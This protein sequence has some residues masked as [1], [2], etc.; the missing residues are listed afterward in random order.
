M[1]SDAAYETIK[2]I[3]LRTDPADSY[4]FSENYFSET[5]HM[6]RTPVRAALQ[7][8]QFEELITIIPHQGIIVRDVSYEEAW[9]LF[10]LRAVVESFLIHKAVG[11]LLDSDFTELEKM[12]QEQQAA[13]D[14]KDFEGFLDL[15]E[16]FH[17]FMYRHYNNPEMIKIIKNFRAR[18]YRIHYRSICTPGQAEKSLASHRK[19]VQLLKEGKT[20]DALAVLK[21]HRAQIEK[22]LKNGD[23]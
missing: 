22:K 18:T 23:R 17:I 4:A 6:S 7:R 10:D 19:M 21:N 12:I 2:K 13:V 11:R 1:K 20:Q 9:Q 8:L 15:D 5:L 3:I 14:R 16:Q